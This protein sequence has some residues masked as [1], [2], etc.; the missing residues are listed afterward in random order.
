MENDFCDAKIAHFN[1]NGAPYIWIKTPGV[2]LWKCEI[3]INISLSSSIYDVL[4]ACMY[5]S[6]IVS[7]NSISINIETHNFKKPNTFFFT[8]SHTSKCEYNSLIDH[9][10]LYVF[11]RCPNLIFASQ[12]S[13][14]RLLYARIGHLACED[15]QISESA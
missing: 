8:S 2:Y 12:V 3:I 10:I 9:N 4:V 5:W 15:A 7:M 1:F 14:S 11:E 6:F 13:D